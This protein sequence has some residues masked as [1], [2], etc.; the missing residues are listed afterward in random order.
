MPLYD[1]RCECGYTE[2]RLLRMFESLPNC[3]K[4]DKQMEMKFAAPPMVKVKGEGGYP[5]RRR[6]I[7]NTTK[8]I[9]PKLT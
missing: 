3:P 7:F 1:L 8:R 6:Q 5:S 4:C 9:H 2:E